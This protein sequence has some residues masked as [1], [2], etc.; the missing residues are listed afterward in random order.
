M[1]HADGSA[2]P[3][4]PGAGEVAEA[5]DL[6]LT[7]ADGTE[8]M[9]YGAAPDAPRGCGAVVL[10]DVRGLHDY[11]R[12]FARALAGAGVAAVAIDYYGRVL[13]D[14]PRDASMAEM[15]PLVDRLA[16]EHVAADAAAAT[17]HLRS[18]ALGPVDAAF[19][20]GFC[21]GG[22]QAWIQSA[23]DH[24]L[25]GCVGFYGRPDDCRPFVDRM[26][27]PLL[28][29]VAGEDALTPVEDFRRFDAELVKAGVAHELV[30][31]GGAP[32]SFFDGGLAEHAA[33][34]EDAW[35]RL[36]AFVEERGGT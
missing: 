34:C 16:P 6:R 25:A 20:I 7:A 30:V 22:S 28:M 35:R 9:A 1:C 23:F 18:G 36:L 26:G 33:A 4:A 27:P 10:P 21:F 15:F 3:G 8:F 17:A 31:Y 24:G 5:S 11:Y 13:P 29:L 14:G 12:G 19:A 32:H 2:P